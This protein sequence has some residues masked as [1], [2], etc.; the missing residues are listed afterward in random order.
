MQ[1]FDFRSDPVRFLFGAAEFGDANLFA[2][3]IVGGQSFGRQERRFFVV[4]N[5]FAGY[6]QDSR[7]RAVILRQRGDEAAHP[8]GKI[9]VGDSAEA[10]QENRE[11]T[12]GSSAKT[13]D[14][15]IV[16]ADRDDI[17]AVAGEQPEQ[18]ELNDVGVLEFVHQDVTKLIAHTLQKRGIRSQ[19]LHRL[20]QLRTEGKQVSLAQQSFADAVNARELVLAGQFFLFKFPH[21]RIEQFSPLK[22]CLPRLVNVKLV[23]IGR[24]HLVLAAR[25]ELTEIVQEFT[26]RRQPPEM[27]Q[28]KLGH[29]APQQD[30]VVDVL[31]YF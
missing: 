21:I 15:L 19:Q 7:C 17:S 4:R 16:I 11:T 1:A 29:V 27:F 26:R 8:V 22:V 30:P 9:L 31:K 18:L 3:G 12:E 14:G 6:A 5:H 20:H 28:V 24:D 25:K 10:L 23:I 13:V 2:V